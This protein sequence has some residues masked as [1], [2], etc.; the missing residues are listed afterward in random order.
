LVPERRRK[1]LQCDIAKRV[2]EFLENG[3]TVFK[4]D[5][6][7]A[8]RRL[9]AEQFNRD[10]AN[11]HAS[12]SWCGNP[13]NSSNTVIRTGLPSEG[14]RAD[15]RN[16][17]NEER[18]DVFFREVL[19]CP[20]TV[21]NC[22][23]WRSLPHSGDGQGPQSWH[24]D[25]C[26]VGILRGVLYLTQVDEDSGPFQYKDE[27]GGVVTMTG[28]PGDLLIFDAV[29]LPHRAMPPKSSARSTIDLVFMPRM[30]RQ[31]LE[32]VSA[33]MNNW[34]SDPFFWGPPQINTG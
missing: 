22:R 23:I 27:T 10:M 31:Q 29:R 32:V 12:W 4:T 5:P 3:I 14:L 8:Q 25:G 16:L 2:E 6:G 26:P 17:F 20:I 24:G 21:A 11:T 1:G 9:V 19:G 30:E 33:G 15:L 7:A 34:P 13:L 18:F 28:G